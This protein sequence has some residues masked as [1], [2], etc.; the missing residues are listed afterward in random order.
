M[1]RLARSAQALGFV[2]D[3]G[4]TQRAITNALAEMG[5]APCAST[6]W[7][8][9][10]ALH[11][12]GRVHTTWASLAP[13]VLDAQGGVSLLLSPQRLPNAQAL[14]AHKTTHRAHYDAGIREA[15]RQGAFDMLFATDDGR[16]TEGARS[17]LFLR[18]DGRWLTPPVGDGALPGVCREAVLAQGLDG[19]P[20]HAQSVS[21]ADLGRAQALRVG[22]ALRGVVPATLRPRG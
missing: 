10:L 13:L 20:V 1:A 19:E 14:S 16:L 6:A 17:S 12:D 18:L 5:P 21:L 2:L 3:E 7:R 15:E 4:A 11:Q 9:R 22:N 8:L